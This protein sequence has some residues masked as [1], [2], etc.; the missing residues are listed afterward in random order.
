MNVFLI[1]PAA[2]IG[3]L[4]LGAVA[5]AIATRRDKRHFPPPGQ[6]VDVGGHR[7]HLNVMGEGKASPTVL[8]EAG[9]ASISSNWGWVQ[10]ELAKTTQVVSYDRAGLGWSEIGEKP[11]DAAK[12]ARELHAALEGLALKVHM[13]LLGTR[14]AG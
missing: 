12:S 6:L 2:I 10:R 4:V 8:L 3:L 11:L 7:L 5:Q 13:C 1:V 9:M 14:T